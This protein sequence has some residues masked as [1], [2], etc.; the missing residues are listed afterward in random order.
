M[1]RKTKS[2]PRC[3][4]KTCTTCLS[5]LPLSHFYAKGKRYESFCKRCKKQRV[6]A[7]YLAKRKSL[8]RADM[9]RFIELAATLHLQRLNAF[10]NEISRLIEERK[11]QNG[12]SRKRCIEEAA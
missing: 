1:A 4:T 2:A 10:E 7:T 11:S 9:T 6:K 3:E 8:S 12:D 5:A